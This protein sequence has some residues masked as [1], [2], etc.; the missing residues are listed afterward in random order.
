MG[1]DAVTTV[2]G[3]V[4]AS[5][6]GITLPHEHALISPGRA[7]ADGRAAREYAISGDPR[8][9]APLSLETVGWVR[10]NWASHPDNVRLDDQQVAIAELLRFKNA[11]GSTIVDATNPDLGRDPVRLASIAEATGLN[12]VMGSGHYL[13]RAHPEDMD[14]RSKEAIRDEIVAD[15]RQGVDGTGIR[16]GIIGE[17]GCSSPL[18][19]NERKSLR[20]AAA[21]QRETGVAML[22]HPGRDAASPRE[23]MEVAL[24]AGADPS[25]VIMSHIDRTLFDIDSML[26]LAETGCYLEFDLFGQESSYYPV[27]P[28][29]L[30]NDATRVDY[31]VRLIAEG[32]LDRLL[33]SQDIC[34]K[35]SLTAYGG[36]GYAH[37][38]DNV[39]PLTQ[40]KGMTE[41]QI[42]A[43]LVRSPARV[44][45]GPPKA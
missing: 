9:S 39:V 30:P 6:L 27:A 32:L 21:A 16:A 31:L 18:T 19:A 44:L 17:I 37:I 20:A 34:R 36:D 2:L 23:T 1:V 28:I 38:L 13:D 35:T 41:D 33:V 4:A 3:D 22:I 7:R 24:E 29:D 8:A 42:D 5:D 11:G 26:D 45:A 25:R 14:D 40:R 12:I 43:I 10:R 15:I